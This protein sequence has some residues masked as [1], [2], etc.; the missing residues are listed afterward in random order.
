M[1]SAVWFSRKV[2]RCAVCVCELKYWSSVRGDVINYFDFMH[3]CQMLSANELK[4]ATAESE[5]A[6]FIPNASAA[7]RPP[8]CACQCGKPVKSGFTPQD[9]HKIG[10]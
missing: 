2:G 7:S 8:R 5:V 6:N 1:A 10:P 3:S 9:V 4:I